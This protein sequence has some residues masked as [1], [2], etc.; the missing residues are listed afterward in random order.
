MSLLITLHAVRSTWKGLSITYRA[1]KT[2]ALVGASGSGKSTI[3]SLVM[4]FY[5]PNSGSV[6]LD[7]NNV[8][9]LNIKWLRSQIGLVSQEPTLFTT[10]VK[11]N[12]AH[13]LIGTEYED[14]PQEQK[15]ALIKEACI[16]LNADGSIT[17]LPNQRL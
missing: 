3:V 17:Q 7:G 14:T 15:D 11:E 4:R 6:T 16:K 8:K 2:A 12:V 10:S 13:G 1:G 9:T 5:D